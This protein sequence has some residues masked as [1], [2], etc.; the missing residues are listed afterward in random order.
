[1]SI[2]TTL[3]KQLLP[4]LLTHSLVSALIATKIPTLRIFAGR[5][6]V[7]RSGTNSSKL[8]GKVKNLHRLLR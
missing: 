2:R 1:L 3:R 6:M 8:K 5:N 4:D 7:I